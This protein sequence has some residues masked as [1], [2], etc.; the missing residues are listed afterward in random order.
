MDL[1]KEIIEE[2]QE[3]KDLFIRFK[4][5]DFKGNTGQAIKNSSFQLAITLIA[6][7]G[8]LLFT[9]IIARMLLPELF[10]L[11]GLALSTIA[12]FLG[13]SDLG[14]GS[15]LITFLGKTESQ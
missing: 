13:F 2:K 4:K 3:I 12:L 15:A 9:I 6:K 10:G 1:K 8:S 14:I 7:I 11:Y 5:R